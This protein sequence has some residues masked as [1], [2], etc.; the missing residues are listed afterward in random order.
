MDTSV[1]VLR[2]AAWQ[3]HVENGKH[4]QEYI[5]KGRMNER[6]NEHSNDEM[7]HCLNS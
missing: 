4:V 2:W 5:I 6:K 1:P 3:E 7:S